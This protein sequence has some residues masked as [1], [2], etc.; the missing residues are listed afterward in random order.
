[1]NRAAQTQANGMGTERGTGSLIDE[2]ESEPVRKGETVTLSRPTN[3][4]SIHPDER[5]KWKFR[6][7]FTSTCRNLNLTP[8]QAEEIAEVIQ[9]EKANAR[10]WEYPY[11]NF[12]LVPSV[13]WPWKMASVCVKSGTVGVSRRGTT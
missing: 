4:T 7:P 6:Y 2:P 9:A 3:V 11:L 1:M 12:Y 10:L 8:E 5:H 13:V